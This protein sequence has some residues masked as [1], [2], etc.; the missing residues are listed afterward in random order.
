MKASL[1]AESVNLSSHTTAPAL[2]HVLAAARRC[3]P[4]FGNSHEFFVTRNCKKDFG[5][6]P[7]TCAAPPTFNSR[8]KIVAIS[9]PRR[10]T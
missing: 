8:E 9:L 3:Q 7:C 10:N 2:Q 1:A 4:K 5:G 6:Q